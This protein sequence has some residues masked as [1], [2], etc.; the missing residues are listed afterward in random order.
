MHANGSR[1]FSPRFSSHN[2]SR[3]GNGGL[4]FLFS[5][6]GQLYSFAPSF[7]FIPSHIPN[8]F[9]LPRTFHARE[10]RILHSYLADAENSLKIVSVFTPGIIF[11]PVRAFMCNCVHFTRCYLFPRSIITFYKCNKFSI[12]EKWKIYRIV[13]SFINFVQIL[14]FE[15]TENWVFE[16]C[17]S[18]SQEQ[19]FHGVKS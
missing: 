7:G 16:S 13:R 4:S 8:R 2:F 11:S 1:Q 3:P 15:I 18:L 19:W 5:V 12:M 6:N 9:V 17:I 10:K 14:L